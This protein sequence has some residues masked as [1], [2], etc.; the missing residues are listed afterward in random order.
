MYAGMPHLLKSILTENREGL[1][2][3]SGNGEGENAF[4]VDYRPFK[5]MDRT[6]TIPSA[7][8]GTTTLQANNSVAPQ[9]VVDKI[10]NLSITLDGSS[11]IDRNAVKITK[12]D[13][14]ASVF[15]VNCDWYDLELNL[16]YPGT[17]VIRNRSV[18]HAASRNEALARTV[19]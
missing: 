10:S 12:K 19:R 1:I 8:V 14:K 11:T 2:L 13:N 4:M 7:F 16:R 9:E 5:L 17:A 15:G 3:G 18:F 6:L